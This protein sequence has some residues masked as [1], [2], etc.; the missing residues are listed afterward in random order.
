[1]LTPVGPT[2]QVRQAREAIPV[3]G[4]TRW[5]RFS[6]LKPLLGGFESISS[7]AFVHEARAGCAANPRSS[8]HEQA[9]RTCVCRQ[10]PPRMRELGC[11]R[12]AVPRSSLAA[13]S[14][15]VARACV[16]SFGIW[17]TVAAAMFS[18]ACQPVLMLPSEATILPCMI[19]SAT[20]RSWPGMMCS[21]RP[22][23]SLGEVLGLRR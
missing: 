21:D 20:P 8:A 7:Q 5:F 23:R 10:H 1:V 4:N 12:D 22:S 6:C 3:G 15:T 18:L 13:L 9:S 17:S 19:R 14:Q 11:W 16:S 2:T